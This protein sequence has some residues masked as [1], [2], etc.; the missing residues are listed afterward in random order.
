MQLT[1]NLLTCPLHLCPS[2]PCPRHE[3]QPDIF[4]KSLETLMCFDRTRQPVIITIAWFH[5]FNPK[6]L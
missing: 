3:H 1:Q 2:T 5:L 6:R 4:Y